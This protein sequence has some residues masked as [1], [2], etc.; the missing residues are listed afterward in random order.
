M[1]KTT[2]NRLIAIFFGVLMLGSTAT[3]AVIQAY[4]MFGN[5]KQQTATLPSTN[6]VQ[7]K[8]GDSVEQLILSQSG[9]VVQ[10]YYSTNCLDCL[11]QR[12]VLENYANQNSQQIY[13]EEIQSQNMTAQNII[14]K[15]YRDSKFLTSASQSDIDNA[16][17]DVLIQPPASCALRNLNTS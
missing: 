14:M 4:N 5:S 6:I 7:G 12:S 1:N 17:C 9:T 15:S 2:R 3:Y 16:F 10:F 13:L 8:L 11:K